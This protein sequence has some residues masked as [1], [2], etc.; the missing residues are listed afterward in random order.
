MDGWMNEWRGKWLTHNYQSSLS[1]QQ[2][3]GLFMNGEKRTPF[4]Y[5]LSSFLL[6]T[7]ISQWGLNVEVIVEQWFPITNKSLISSQNCLGVASLRLKF[8]SFRT[9]SY[10]SFCICHKLGHFDIRLLFLCAT[11]T[12]DTTELS[13]FTFYHCALH[14][15]YFV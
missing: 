2:D 10:K 15:C 4:A 5:I 12:S 8:N 7:L 13:F 3:L 1:I 9:F 6:H 14:Y 11:E